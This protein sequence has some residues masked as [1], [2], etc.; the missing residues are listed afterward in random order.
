MTFS[1]TP[2]STGS[3]T[4]PPGRASGP[5]P[6]SVRAGP[7]QPFAPRTVLVEEEDD[8][9]L[10]RRCLDGDQR[11]FD[12]LIVRYQKPVFNAAL[13]M[14]RNPEDARDVAQTV[15]LKVFE[16][17]ADYDPNLRFYSWI[18]RI[19]LNESI[20]ALGRLRRCE[21]ITGDEVDQAPG[22]ERQVESEQM[23]SAI[24]S[25]LMRIQPDY[26]AVIV[27]RHFLHL[28]YEDIGDILEVPEKTVKSRLYTARQLLRDLLIEDGAELT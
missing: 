6:E 28:G 24:E 25:S 10:V 4:S 27:L 14:V 5:H 19:A 13:R 23:M 3:S 26:R 12:R 20:N 9:T 22:L 1:S 7:D 11:A 16:H 8:G 18:Y 17:L 21:A 15:F 2:V